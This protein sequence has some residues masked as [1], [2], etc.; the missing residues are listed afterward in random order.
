MAVSI[1]RL[2]EIG[3]AP[4]LPQNDRLN[5]QV[6]D[7]SNLIQAQTGAVA[8]LGDKVGDIYQ[9]YEND[10]ID[11][12]SSVA[13]QEYDSWNKQALAKLKAHEGDP[14]DAYV[15]YDKQSKQ[16]RDDILNARP[17][18]NDRVKRHFT[19]RLDKTVGKAG[20]AADYQRGMQQEV[21]AN[22]VFES[23]VKL[24]KDSLPVAAGYVQADDPSTF[25]MFDDGMTDIKTLVAKRAVSKGTA[26]RLADDAPDDAP[27]S[28]KYLDDDGKIVR[29]NMGPIAKQRVAKE[30][31]EGVVSSIDVLV[32]SGNV[33][34]AKQM[35]EKYKGYITHTAA[36]KLEKK[37]KATGAKD[38]AFNVIG[39]LKGKSDD[40]QLRVIDSISDP[41]VRSEALKIK[42]T[43][44]KRIVALKERKEKSNYNVL[45]KNILEKQNSDNPYYG[46]ADLEADPIFKQTYDKMN[47]KQQQAVIEMVEAPK[48]SSEKALLKVQGLFLGGSEETIETMTPEDFAERT[49][50]LS[51]ADKKKYTNMFVSLRAQTEGEKRSMYTQAGNML[52]DQLISD[53]LIQRNSYNKIAGDD[54]KTLIEAQQELTKALG[55]Q[56]GSFNPAQLQQFVKDYSAAKVKGKVFNPESRKPAVKGETK[57]STGGQIKMNR[58]EYNNLVRLYSK[59]NNNEIPNQN[60]PKFVNFVQQNR[61]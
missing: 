45:A 48:E 12:L 5:I 58:A 7:N 26:T 2:K 28:H 25:T 38:E 14:T 15:E 39:S 52:R 31:S 51:K 32:S 22:N 33:E 19:A 34:A 50:G 29:V 54:E 9:A 37:F 61:R 40:E 21:Y 20:I 44:D 16:K 49:V 23:T 55:S 35:Q 11:Q 57:P 3:Q 1:P 59:K 4:A 17:D 36:A 42:D 10:K 6:K 43:D 46:M 27:Y 41:E 13:E 18:L 60:D 24:K 30:L 47:A 53:G 8:Q 56:Y